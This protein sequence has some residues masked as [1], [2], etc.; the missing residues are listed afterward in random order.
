M[1]L[2]LTPLVS[3]GGTMFDNIDDE[4]QQT[5]GQPVNRIQQLLRALSVVGVTTVL[6]GSLYLGILFLE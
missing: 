6:F 2:G 3:E 1:C 4:I 5:N